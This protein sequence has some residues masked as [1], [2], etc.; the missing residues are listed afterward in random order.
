MGLKKL[1]HYGEKFIM[2]NDYLSND[3]LD[4]NEIVVLFDAYDVLLFPA[5]R[6]VAQVCYIDYSSLI[7]LAIIVIVVIVF[8]IAT[9]LK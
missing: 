9:T 4:D 5:M 1:H 6:R 8:I 2:Y 7:T 3:V